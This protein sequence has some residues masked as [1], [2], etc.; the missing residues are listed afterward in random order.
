MSR[1][2]NPMLG[3]HLHHLHHHRIISSIST[4]IARGFV[5][6][7]AIRAHL[8]RSPRRPLRLPLSLSSRSYSESDPSRSTQGSQ[9]SKHE[10]DWKS[11]VR[12]NWKGWLKTI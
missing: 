2:S 11:E 8:L 9:S 5:A 7:S 6:N 4:M 3:L 10:G 1:L 12:T